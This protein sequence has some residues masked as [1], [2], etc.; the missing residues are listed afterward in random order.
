MLCQ[1]NGKNLSTKKKIVVSQDRPKILGSPLICGSQR[2]KDSPNLFIQSLPLY[3]LFF[4]SMLLNED[5]VP[6]EKPDGIY[7]LTFVVDEISG[8]FL[9]PLIFSTIFSRSA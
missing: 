5:I 9:H 7:L 3:T 6:I 1:D 8:L 2:V 4:F